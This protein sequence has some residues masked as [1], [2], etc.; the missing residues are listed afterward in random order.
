MKEAY[1]EYT[2]VIEARASFYIRAPHSSPEVYSRNYLAAITLCHVIG[3]FTGE[4]RW[5]VYDRL[6][7]AVLNRVPAK[8]V[9]A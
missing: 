1:S 6:Q 2:R 8:S 7:Q 4:D 9:A 3:D 5:D